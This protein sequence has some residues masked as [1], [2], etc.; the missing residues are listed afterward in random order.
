MEAIES[1]ASRT[2]PEALHASRVPSLD[3]DVFGWPTSINSCN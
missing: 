2:S 1:N 3:H